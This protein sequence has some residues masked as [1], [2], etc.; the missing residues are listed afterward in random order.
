MNRNILPSVETL[1]Q[2]SNLKPIKYV[3]TKIF[4]MY[5]MIFLLICGLCCFCYSCD[6]LEVVLSDNGQ[7]LV[8]VPKNKRARASLLTI[9]P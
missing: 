7:V 8:L 9:F 1:N 3:Y 2:T 4:E 5:L 6:S